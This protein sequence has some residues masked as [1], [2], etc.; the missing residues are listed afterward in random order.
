[1]LNLS[2]KPVL[3]QGRTGPQKPEFEG[4]RHP[5]SFASKL[6]VCSGVSEETKRSIL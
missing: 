4:N 5:V 1:V 2:E 6:F 3:T